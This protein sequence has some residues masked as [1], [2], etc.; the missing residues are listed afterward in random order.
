M[1][2]DKPTTAERYARAAH[3]SHL[4]MSEH[5]QGDVDMIAAAGM[6][7]GIGPKLL[8]LMTEYDKVAKEVRKTADN[9]LTG[10]L[11]ILMELRTLRETKEALHLWALDRATKRR[12]MLSDKQ[13]A[14]IVGGCLSSFLSPT[15]PTC[16]G[17]GLIGGYDGSIQN[18]C[19]RCGG[20]GKAKDAVGLD[21]V[22]KDFAADLMHAMAGAYS[23]AE[24][25]IR[26]QLA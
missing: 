24:M 3:T 23:F 10:M 1:S 22:Q 7:H 16:N 12:V 11:L 8:R 9:D 18:I 14:A 25:E 19:R 15:C 20:S 13:I 2:D 6:V 17:T 21:F 5:R 4:G 26:R